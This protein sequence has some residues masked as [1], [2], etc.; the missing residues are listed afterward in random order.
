MMLFE[1]ITIRGMTLKNRIVMS[2]MLTNAGLR[3]KRSRAYL[4]ERAK[5]GVGAIAIP[6]PLI[7]AFSLDEVWGKAGAVQSFIESL[8]VIPD[9]VHPFGTKI[10]M[11]HLAL[12]RIPMGI[13]VGDA[14]GELVAPSPGIEKL[15][16]RD[17]VIVKQGEKARQ[18]TITEIET[19]IERYARAAAG[20]KAGGFDFTYVHGAHGSLTCQFWAPGYNHRTD[21]Y[22]GDLAGRM[23]FGIEV[24]T[25][26][27]AAVGDD[28][29]IFYR[30]GVFG[31]HGVTMRDSITFAR[32]LAKAG[33]DVIDVCNVPH[34][35]M[36]QPGPDK[37]IGVF[38]PKAARIKKNVDIPIGVVGKINRP[39]VAEAILTEGKADLIYIGRQLLCDPYWALKAQEGKTDEIVEC[40]CCNKCSPRHG[41]IGLEC[42][43]NPNLTRE[44]EQ[45][46]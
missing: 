40:L 46:S 18:L 25:A 13:G 39:D 10:G 32:E 11:Q 22:G 31:G 8:H 16:I 27:R 33:T 20:A 43:L 42:P 9:E 14:Q 19:A 38:A 28:F 34:T 6:G 24:V 12:N 5:G 44:Y 7:D 30:L 3:G 23:R 41:S 21:R 15:L 1:P 4:A 17:G 35:K 26:M 2:P 36:G 45:V 29:P 37:P